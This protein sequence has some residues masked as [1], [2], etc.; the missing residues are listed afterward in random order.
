MIPCVGHAC[1]RCVKCTRRKSPRCCRGDNPNYALPPMGSIA[2]FYGAL[3]QVAE[4][5]TE[6]QCHVCGLWW[7]RLAKHAEHTHD[8]TAVEYRSAFGLAWTQPLAGAAIRDGSRITLAPWAGL[9]L[10]E[11]QAAM[12]RERRQMLSAR[13]ARLQA[14]ANRRS[15]RA[16]TARR[17]LGPLSAATRGMDR[18]HARLAC[19][20]CGLDFAAPPSAQ[21][22]GR[23]T[24][25]RKACSRAYRLSH[26]RPPTNAKLSRPVA[27]AIRA[28]YLGGDVSQKAIADEFGVTQSL[29]SM[30]VRGVIWR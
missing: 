24:C 5:D 2:P 19:A 11:A 1:D 26:F 17:V 25:G 10:S 23:V 12:T 8:L 27:N 9:H 6:Q 3:G 18:G 4:D 20:V 16:E 29:V 28:R 30:I 14:R 21:Q 22:R 13:P 15:Q 7:Q